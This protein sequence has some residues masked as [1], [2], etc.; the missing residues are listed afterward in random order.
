MLEYSH[1]HFMIFTGNTKSTE[2]KRRNTKGNTKSTEQKRRN[3]EPKTY[4]RKRGRSRKHIR[5]RREVQREIKQKIK[6]EDNPSLES[7]KVREQK[8]K[9][10]KEQG[11]KAQK[12]KAA[13][14][15]RQGEQIHTP[16]QHI[17]TPPRCQ[18]RS[19]Q[20]VPRAAVSSCERTSRLSLRGPR[21]RS[22]AASIA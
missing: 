17:T 18:L 13:E 7:R 6:Q 9:E 12:S 15:P 10:T 3:T 8:S 19:R 11:S 1:A 5:M 22:F 20:P 2:Q 14:F 4:K 16:H 21:S